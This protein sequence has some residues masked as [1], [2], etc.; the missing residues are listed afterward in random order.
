VQLT[1]GGSQ[2]TAARRLG[3]PPGRYPA[4]AGFHVQRW[5]RDG[6]NPAR[7]H[8]ALHTLA[9]ELDATPAS[10]LIDYGRRRDA[11]TA[12]SLPADDWHELATD[13]SGRQHARA[14]VS[15][16]WGERKRRVASVLVW[17]RVTQGEYLFAPLVL[18]DS[19]A[20][21]RSELAQGGCIK[22]PAGAA[23]AILTTTTPLS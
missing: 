6:A 17:A 5:A 14:R 1:Q 22:R 12:W 23:P 10:D 21:G 18:Q 20:S 15:T 9:A 7:L 16:S 4:A 8:A 11:L 19:Q 13:L 2:Q 3:L